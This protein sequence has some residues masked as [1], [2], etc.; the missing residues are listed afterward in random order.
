MLDEMRFYIYKVPGMQKMIS[1]QSLSVSAVYYIVRKQQAPSRFFISSCRN[2][3]IEYNLMLCAHF[4]KTE[5]DTLNVQLSIMSVFQ[6]T[7][8]LPSISTVKTR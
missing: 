2:S 4:L 5:S 3:F 6:K 1:F 7:V 8:T